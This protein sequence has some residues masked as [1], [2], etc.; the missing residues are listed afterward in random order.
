MS[1]PSSTPAVRTR[2]ENAIALARLLER[3]EASPRIDAAA[4]RQLVRQLEAT[5]AEEL[6]GAVLD[7][8]LKTHPA[9]AVVYE[10][11]HYAQSGLSRTP[12][13]RSVASEMLAAKLIAQ[14]AGKPAA[15]R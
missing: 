1:A 11:M 6:P 14:I 13:E 4:Y 3:V 12:L 7:A 15:S 9:A 2:I 8:I 5:L 10:N